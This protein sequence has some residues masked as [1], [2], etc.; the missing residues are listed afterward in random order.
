MKSKLFA[1]FDLDNKDNEGLKQDLHELMTLTVAQRDACISSL[2]E[3]LVAMT[4]PETRSLLEK[5]QAA[6][7]RTPVVLERIVRVL[8]FFA[9]QMRDDET[10][11]DT[12]RQWGEDLAEHGV[13]RV[14]EVDPFADAIESLAQ[15]V[16]PVEAELKRLRYAT[17]VLPSLQSLGVT[18]ELRAVQ[19]SRYRWGAPLSQYKPK[20]VDLTPVA[21]IH[22]GTDVKE[23][24]DFYFQANARELQF[25]IDALMAAK[26]DL[27]A[28]RDA[29]SLS[30]NPRKE[31]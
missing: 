28:L 22:I 21:S 31:P 3:F 30:S 29:V 10:R 23:R 20:I 7:G 24:K 2:P 11:G 4:Q 15:A 1:V 19:D 17:G 27:E 25:M 13:L 12:G 5:L 14:A 26:L 9:K 6:T 16:G 18:V 8:E